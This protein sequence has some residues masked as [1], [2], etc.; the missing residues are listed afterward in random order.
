MRTAVEHQFQLPR[1]VVRV[2]HAA[3]RAARAERRH[4]VC[5]I[6]REQHAAVAERVHPLAAERIDAHPLELELDVRAEQ[7]AHTRNH[8]LRLLLGDRVGIP[9]ELEVDAPHVVRLAVQQHRLVAVKRRVE[10]EPTLGRK[11]R[12]HLHV[13]D[14]ETVLERAAAAFETHHRAHRAARA[15]G[16]DHV[17]RAQRRDAVRR[18]DRQHRVFGRLVDARHLVLPADIDVRQ[19]ECAVGQIAFYVVLLQVDE[20]R[21][22]MPLLGQQVERVKLLVLQE[23]LADVPAHALVDEALAAAEPVEDLERA[24]GEADR[25]RAGR[26]R[27]VVVEQHDRHALLREVDRGGQ[28][29]RARADDDHRV[30]GRVVRAGAVLELQRLVIDAHGRHPRVNPAVRAPPRP[31]LRPS[32]CGAPA[33]LSCQQPPRLAPCFLLIRER[34]RFAAPACRI[35]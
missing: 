16:R 33:R 1:E 28:A 32:P 34:R 23:H 18:L 31:S 17:L 9:A 12:L 19:L 26:Q 6:A 22:R 21:A 20:R 15:V 8:A 30:D 11:L 13:G 7:R 10:P 2:L 4:A 14:Q 25:A 35:S 27:V 3:V 5:G 29:H 24:L